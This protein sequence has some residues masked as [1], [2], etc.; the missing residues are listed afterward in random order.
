VIKWYLAFSTLSLSLCLSSSAQGAQCQSKSQKP[1]TKSRLTAIAIAQGTRATRVERA[2]EQFARA[3]NRTFS[4]RPLPNNTRPIASLERA[5][6]TR[7]KYLSIIP[8]SISSLLYSTPSGITLYTR[9]VFHEIKAISKTTLPPST[10]QHQVTGYLDVLRNTPSQ[11][12]GIPATLIF[13][14]SSD[15]NG[16]GGT[17]RLTAT[18]RRINLEHAIACELPRTGSTPLLQFGTTTIQNPELFLLT[19]VLFLPSGPGVTGRMPVLP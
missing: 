8:D 18:A 16:V 3:T 6:A 12:S 13:L 11:A 14:T 10:A 5:R 19:G 9:S 17:T 7:G 2:F 1:L 15:V 4:G